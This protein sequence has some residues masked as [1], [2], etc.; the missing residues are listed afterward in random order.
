MENL[1]WY[2]IIISCSALLTAIGVY[3]WNR[4]KH[5]WFWTETTVKETEISDVVAYNHANGIMW[6][7]YSLIYW[8][9]ALASVW[10]N[11]TALILI[12]VG[13]VIGLP[14]LSVVYKRIYKKYAN[15]FN[16]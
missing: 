1:I 14:L 5:M 13:C 8:A 12:I 2:I 11:M 4:K 6:G 10:S 16:R 9:A 7:V 3:A 15:N